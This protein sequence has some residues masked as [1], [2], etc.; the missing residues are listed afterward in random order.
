MAGQDR[1]DPGGY[2]LNKPFQLRLGIIRVHAELEFGIDELEQRHE[3]GSDGRQMGLDA[4]GIAGIQKAM[5]SS[6]PNRGS[7]ASVAASGS[8]GSVAISSSCTAR[9]S[10]SWRR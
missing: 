7:D 9:P 10:A 8:I 5:A 2:G 1:Q 3:L 4:L 6:T